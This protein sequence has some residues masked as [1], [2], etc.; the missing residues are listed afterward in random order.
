MWPLTKWVWQPWYK[1][2]GSLL[3][4]KWPEEVWVWSIWFWTEPFLLHRTVHG[5]SRPM[6]STSGL[7]NGV[8]SNKLA[9]DRRQ[10]LNRKARN[11]TYLSSGLPAGWGRG[12]CE[13]WTHRTSR[14]AGDW[15]GSAGLQGQSHALAPRTVNRCLCVHE[16][17]Q[18]K[19]KIK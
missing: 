10:L 19:K 5:W 7:M 4:F 17:K 9:L 6:Y 8:I 15:S 12:K 13:M 11:M 18:P 1:Q 16:K 3:G 14:W 2:E